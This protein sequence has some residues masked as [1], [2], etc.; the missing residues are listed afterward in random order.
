VTRRIN[1]ESVLLLAG[2]R[3]LLMQL[4]HP[5]V[6]AGVDEHSDFRRRPL[7]RLLRTLELTLTLTF[8]D[9]REALAAA[10][11]IN[12]TH[13][14]VRG[15]GYSAT[16]PRLLFWVQATLIDSAVV[17]YQT[18]VGRLQ[19]Q[20]RDEYLAEAQTVGRLLGVPPEA[21]PR[22]FHAFENYMEGML[23]GSELRVD[24]RAR[25]L[26]TY[27]LHPPVKGVPAA[28]WAPLAAVT[29]GL[30]PQ[31]LREA[32]RL[33]WRRRERALF[34]GARWSVPRLLPLLPPA[35][36]TV[37]PARAAMPRRRTARVSGSRINP[38]PMKEE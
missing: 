16:E 8:G 37:P 23:S 25:E 18:F 31:S 17:A 22:D 27:V 24:G 13:Q 34:A 15:D 14:G 4:A 21:F 1:S 36:R 20:E 11:A 12:R 7:A 9:R 10:H 32:Y 28:A 35:L 38:K 33:P 19:A 2:G 29:G 26:A 3:A 5:A 6:A 30:L